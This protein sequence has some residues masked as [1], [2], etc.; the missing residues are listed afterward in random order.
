MLEMKAEVG[1]GLQFTVDVRSH[2]DEEGMRET[3]CAKK[4]E[5]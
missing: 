2:H 3:Q 4:A 1:G 5:K